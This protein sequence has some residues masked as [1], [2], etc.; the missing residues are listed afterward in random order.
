M[1]RIRKK[2]QEDR[3]YVADVLIDFISYGGEAI[4]YGVRALIKWWN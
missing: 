1:G 3:W 2:K 4:L